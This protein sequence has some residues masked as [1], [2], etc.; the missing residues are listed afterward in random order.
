MHKYIEVEQSPHT[1]RAGN[2]DDKLPESVF[3]LSGAVSSLCRRG[4]MNYIVAVVLALMIGPLARAVSP[5]PA[6]GRHGMVVT[7]QHL[8]SEVGVDILRQGGNRSEEH[9]SELQS[10]MRISYAVFCL[11]KKK[12]HKITTKDTH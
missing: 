10:L 4:A 3:T 7:A 5:Q 11:K 2:C 9:T 6:Y 12:P 1:Q 8:A